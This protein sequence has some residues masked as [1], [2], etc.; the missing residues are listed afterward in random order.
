MNLLTKLLRAEETCKKYYYKRKLQK[1]K[2]LML[3][4]Q[5]KAKNILQ[6]I[7]KLYLLNKIINYKPNFIEFEGYKI[8]FKIECSQLCLSIFMLLRGKYTQSL[9]AALQTILLK[10]FSTNILLESSHHFNVRM[11]K[12]SANC[13]LQNKN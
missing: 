13:L 5:T 10:L 12:K 6:M 1:R 4:R 2:K 8:I 9:R 3:K 11:K 7:E